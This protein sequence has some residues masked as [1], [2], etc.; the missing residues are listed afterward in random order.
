[1]TWNPDDPFPAST[2]LGE[3]EGGARNLPGFL[4]SHLVPGPVLV[5]GSSEVALAAARSHEVIVVD[6]NRRRLARLTDCLRERG[7]D[8]HVLCRD[9]EGQE[10]GV[11]PRSVTN[12]VCLDVLE[13][14]RSDVG[15]LEKLHRTLAP[16]GR[17]VARVRACSWGGEAA[18]GSSSLRR[19]GPESL[20]GALEEAGFRTLSVR[21][22]NFLGVP[23][24]Y[25]CGRWLDRA[26]RLPEGLPAG[27][28][29]R[30][31]WDGPLDFWF[32]AVENRV[33]FPTGVSL[34]S[35]A[36]PHLEKARVRREAL[37]PGAAR[38]APREAYEPM[39][40]SR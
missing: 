29:P 26:P 28:R 37:P 14:F 36:A 13:R 19:Y 20:R 34:V 15:V 32:R 24:A 8:A 17:L 11:R 31:W 23:S 16:E 9:P 27:E 22:W 30:H 25:V 40:A 1:M 12:V 35:V 33:G 2:A 6:W 4:C 7:R 5:L 39:A 38:R 18:R 10:L 3:T 21:Y